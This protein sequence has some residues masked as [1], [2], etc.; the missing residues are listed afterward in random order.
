M[1]Q[2]KKPKK[3]RMAQL[4]R[5]IDH[6]KP[7]TI[8]AEAEQDYLNY[9]NHGELRQRSPDVVKKTIRAAVVVVIVT[10]LLAISSLVVAI[11]R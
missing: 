3:V 1:K 2:G 7:S 9:K 11:M 6:Y 4:K 10:L 5:R 8:R